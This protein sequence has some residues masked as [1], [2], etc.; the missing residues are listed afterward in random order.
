MVRQGSPVNRSI[1]TSGAVTEEN[2]VMRYP[3]RRGP[4]NYSHPDFVP[5]FLDEQPEDVLQAA[6][7]K[8]GDSIACI[9]DY[10]ATG[11]A[12]MADASKDTAGKADDREKLSSEWH[13]RSCV[14]VLIKDH[15]KTFK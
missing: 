10:V 4:A 2:T 7:A 5:I 8:C 13:S 9:Y 3:P 15:I 14:D 6:R 11:S 12:A 1:F